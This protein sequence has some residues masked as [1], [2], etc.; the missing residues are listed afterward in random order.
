MARLLDCDIDEVQA[1][2]PRAARTLAADTGAVV[3]LKG[4]PTLVSDPGG[5]LGVSAVGG[6]ELAVAGM[7]DVLTGA[8]AGLLAQ[9]LDAGSACGLA[10]VTTAL[11][12]QRSGLG[13]G[14]AASDVPDHIPH[15]LAELGPGQSELSAPWVVLDMGAAR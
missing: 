13:P 15:A 4:A 8:V 11:A 7:G 14:L 3:V 9:G 12:A 1:D 10:L 5:G 2:R 6:S